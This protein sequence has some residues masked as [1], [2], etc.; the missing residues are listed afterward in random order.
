MMLN[1]SDVK[2][3]G[4]EAGADLVGIAPIERFKG[5]PPDSDPRFINPGTK[6]V[7]VLAFRLPRGALRGVEEG[8]AWNTMGVGNPTTVAIESTYLFCRELESAGWEATPLL[9]HS[10][11]LRRQGVRVHPDKP[12]PN[13]IL[14]LEYAAHAAGLGEIGRGKLFLTPE[15]GV[16]QVLTAVLTDAEI[17]PDGTFRGALCDECGECARAC[18][19]KAIA[20]DAA[21]EQAA[22]CEGQARWWPVTLESCRVCRTGPLLRPYSADGDP[23][24]MGAACG[25]ACVA[26]LED[27]GKLARRFRHPFREAAPAP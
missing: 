5:L 18:P 3:I 13:V 19:A 15:F 23:L 8:T 1:G 6:S 25:R 11:E 21:C 9:H 20:R 16:R 24:R 22:L 7:V 4:R 10:G 12:E 14:D 17:E 26:H 27:G 2:R